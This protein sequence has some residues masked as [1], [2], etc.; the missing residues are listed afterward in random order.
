M[1]AQV[2]KS[3]EVLVVA[4]IGKLEL[5]IH[6][7]SGNGFCYRRFNTN[8]MKNEQ[9]GYTGYFGSWTDNPQYY[10]RVVMPNTLFH[11]SAIRL[12]WVC[13]FSLWT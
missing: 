10:S 4:D 7:Q 11:R 13:W 8:L 1:A 12:K 2:F 3:Q 9:L 5:M 6:E